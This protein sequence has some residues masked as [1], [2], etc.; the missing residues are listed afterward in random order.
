VVAKGDWYNSKLMARIH[1]D[2]D[3][4]MPQLEKKWWIG[5]PYGAQG[6]G[7]LLGFAFGDQDT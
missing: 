2:H 3:H 7:I 6:K 5:E 4:M 1:G